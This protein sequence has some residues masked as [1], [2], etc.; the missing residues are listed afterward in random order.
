VEIAAHVDALEGE[1]PLMADATLAA[2]PDA[3]VPT[4]PDWTVR[5]L[6][7]H[8]GQVHRWATATVRSASLDP[9]DS[10]VDG[11][12]EDGELVDWLR[13]GHAAL[14]TALRAAPADLQCFTFL[15]AP[16]PLAM[17]SR[18]QLHET[19][20]H[21]VDAESAAGR[22]TT[23]RADVA[24][25]GIDELLTCFI[26]RSRGRLRLDPARTIA[27]AATDVGAG[28]TMTV[29]TE[30]VATVPE[31]DPDADLVVRGPAASLYLWLWNRAD[32]TDLDVAGDRS[33][34]ATWRE[35]VQI[36]WR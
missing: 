2:G 27:V 7:R 1:G 3:P 23:P 30:P 19:T 4:C 12:P 13:D 11:W 25:D 16:S 20:I 22:R 10:D 35:N 24:A 26:T 9:V 31:A 15:A 6:V 36:S 34:L 18:R 21:R 28:W 8:T 32:A 5:D 14:V 29:S 33:L 17:W